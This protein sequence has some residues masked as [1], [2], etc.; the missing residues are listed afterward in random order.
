MIILISYRRDD[1][2]DFPRD[3]KEKGRSVQGLSVRAKRWLPSREKKAN[4]Q[5]ELSASP[6]RGKTS[7]CP[8]A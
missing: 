3:R 8:L 2:E 6:R 7:A 4:V 5:V 1:G